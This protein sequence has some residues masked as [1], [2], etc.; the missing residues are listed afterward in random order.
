MLDLC[1]VKCT[2]K[3]LCAVKSELLHT[4]KIVCNM[5]DANAEDSLEKRY[6][7]VSEHG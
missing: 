3:I 5:M 4:N 2:Q 7:C 6:K 1:L